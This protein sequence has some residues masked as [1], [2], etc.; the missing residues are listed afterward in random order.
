VC[1][2][3]LEWRWVLRLIFL[4]DLRAGCAPCRYAEQSKFDEAIEFSEKALGIWIKVL[5]EE[6]PHIAAGY[7]NL[8]N[9]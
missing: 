6:H 2:F 5:G 9:M 8:G 7:N 1:A 3:F 4:C